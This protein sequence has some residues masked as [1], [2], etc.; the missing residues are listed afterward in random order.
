MKARRIPEVIQSSAMDCG[1]AA[2]AALLNG[3]GHQVSYPRLREVCQ[4]DVD[5]TSIDT[6]ETLAVRFG[7]HAEQ[8]MLPSDCLFLASTPS[9]PCIAVTTLPNG[10][11]HFVVVWRARLGFVQIMDPARGR[12][13][14]RADRF[15]S[16]LYEHQTA[17][18]A[19]DWNDYAHSDEFKASL[20]E[21]L[22]SIGMS[23]PS[24]STR[25]AA[26]LADGGW[27]AVADLDAAVRMCHVL[28]HTA[29]S[30]RSKPE[31]QRLL[32][33][34]LD[35]PELIPDHYRQV[36]ATS[37]DPQTLE[38]KGAILVRV[39]GTSQPAA[40]DPVVAQATGHPQ[41]STPMRLFDLCRTLGTEKLMRSI[42]ASAILIGLI[43]FIEALV[44]RYLIGAQ[45]PAELP[46]L[47]LIALVV[48][49]PLVAAIALESGG[50]A[51]SQTLGRRLDL[52]LRRRLLHKL[53]RMADGYFASRLVSDL[54]E[55]GH[56][57]GQIR[58]LTELV[59]RALVLAVRILLVMLGLAWLSPDAL[60]L[61]TAAIVAALITPFFIFPVLA[62]RDLR[63]RTHL[64]ALARFYLDSLRGSE[65]IWAHGAGRS[66]EQEQE[67]LLLKWAQAVR[68]FQRPSLLF[69]LLQILIL[70]GIGIALVL[71]ALES[72]LAQGTVL[73]VAYWAVFVPVLSRQLTDV[74]KQLPSI[75][76]VAQRVLELTDAPEEDVGKATQ[77]TSNAS[78]G[79][80]LDFQGLTIRRGDQSL[81]EDIELHISSGERIAIVGHSGSGKSSFIGV[82]LG[83]HS[84]NDRDGTLLIDGKPAN[85]ES[86]AALRES[87]VVIDPDLYLWNRSLFDNICYGLDTVSAAH[88]EGAIAGSELINDLEKMET[89]LATSTGENGSRLSGGEGQRLRI[90]RGL[91]RPRPR[92]V[93]LD[94]PFLG[95]DSAQRLRMRTSVI[96]RFS[97]ST[98]LFV[99]HN[100]S[101]T[102]DFE[103]VLVFRSGRIVEDDNPHTLLSRADSTFA[104]M[105]AAE[106]TLQTRLHS[107]GIWHHRVIDDGVLRAP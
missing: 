92:L 48:I 7:L 98:V 83:W 30:A 86:M 76:S 24:A 107:G 14:M 93:L 42:A 75:G 9:L 90:A 100:V 38:L 95:M 61:I 35:S 71:N 54:A 41:P 36:V 44:F 55:R 97:D 94:E 65:A 58:D 3:Y 53:P 64:G 11:T 15:L 12:S 29:D 84:P 32:D 106:R 26:T 47:G 60:W 81:I 22:I 1:P 17:V 8:I 103:R 70:I 59:R 33:T 23:E 16:Q 69:E 77:P 28:L 10:L 68:E 78:A 25:T 74:L 62:E 2:L 101:E 31:R 91:V 57:V 56:A 82:L 51:L 50:V 21:R 27:K 5:G 102:L 19:D 37:G 52:N 34:L 13:W 39:T 73:L 87:S 67:G 6:L 20:V 72:G 63:A 105:V 18:T 79:A 99:S 88:L 43:T 49:T 96:D 40:D 85:P 66:I 104:R 89:G 4:T 45:L 46:A 80:A